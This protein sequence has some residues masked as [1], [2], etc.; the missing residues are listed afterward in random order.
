MGLF[1][2]SQWVGGHGEPFYLTQ[3]SSAQAR[4]LKADTTQV[5]CLLLLV[6]V[7]TSQAAL[8]LYSGR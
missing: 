3:A 1:A 2:F 6:I 7:E 5:I 8:D 4:C